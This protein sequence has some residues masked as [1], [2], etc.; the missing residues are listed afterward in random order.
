MIINIVVEK[1]NISYTNKLLK[2]RF[3]LV[4]NLIITFSIEILCIGRVQAAGN[5]S[6]IRSYHYMDAQLDRSVP[7]TYYRL[8]QVDNDGSFAYSRAVSVRRT[9]SVVTAS[10]YP[11]P[12]QTDAAV[13]IETSGS[14]AS[15]QVFNMSGQRMQ[16]PILNI[17]NRKAELNL[18]S[19]ASGVY[20]LQLKTSDGDS[21]K[22]LVVK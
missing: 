3:I 1:Y 14:I 16:V 2:Q 11:N 6:A 13:T 8:R 10:L 15:I 20:V 21:T 12:A 7:V 4:F 18:N 5:S 9:E 19:L 17:G 22:K